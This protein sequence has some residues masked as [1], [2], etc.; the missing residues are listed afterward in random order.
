MQHLFLFMRQKNFICNIVEKFRLLDDVMSQSLA[1]TCC[2]C[3]CYINWLIA[4][5]TFQF[6]LTLV[7]IYQKKTR[8][9]KST[10]TKPA[11]CTSELRKAFGNRFC[12]Q[13]ETSFPSKSMDLQITLAILSHLWS[14]SS[15]SVLNIGL[16]RFLKL[17]TCILM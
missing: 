17:N 8:N 10:A 16:C 7:Y 6:N 13:W 4:L 11:Y 5:V 9:L 15:K 3:Y 2:T 1:L 14:L 12:K